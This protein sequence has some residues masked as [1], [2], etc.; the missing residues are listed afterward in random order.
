M[1]FVM[2]FAPVRLSATFVLLCAAATTAAATDADTCRNLYR[3]TDL[4]HAIEPGIP[5]AATDTLPAHCR[6]RGV[7]NRAIRFEVTLPEA[8][9]GRLMFEAVG[10]SAG[11]IGDTTSLLDRGFAQ[12]STDTGHEIDEGNDF[13]KQ[14]EALL[15]YAY[16]GVH[17][18]TQASK[19]VIA[20][21]YGRDIDP[22]L[23]EGLFQRRSGGD[24]RS[25]SVS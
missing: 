5:V 10:G 18:A 22:R 1:T 4:Q 8:W 13:V 12:A 3:L 11:V 25:G 6:V 9:N 23:P 7:V 14:P 17:L 15:D 20:R 24:A 19:R 21:Y 2:S 16:R